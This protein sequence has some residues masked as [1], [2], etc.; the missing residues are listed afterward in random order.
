MTVVLFLILLLLVVAVIA[1][2]W[3][4]SIGP[5]G[6]PRGNTGA[7]LI[8]E[9]TV[10]DLAARDPVEAL[11]RYGTPADAERLADEG[12]DLSALGHRPTP[13]R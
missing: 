7:L 3:S 12:V 9:E 10:T 5:P 8:D 4:R 13:E 11:L 2:N 6:P 1:S